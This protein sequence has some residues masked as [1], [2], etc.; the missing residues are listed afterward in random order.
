MI[1]NVDAHAKNFALLHEPRGGVRVA[2]R[3]D[4]MPTRLYRDLTDLL[5]YAIG[6]ATKLTEITEEHFSHF[7]RAFGI[8]TIGAQRRLTMGLTARLSQG[9]TAELRG[10]DRNGMKRFADLIGH[11]VDEILAAFGLAVPDEIRQRDA[12]IDRGGG[13]LLGS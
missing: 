1:G 9:L 10:M 3:Y 8:G 6:E 2:P 11:N 7:L 5:P 4:L 13:W 12:Y